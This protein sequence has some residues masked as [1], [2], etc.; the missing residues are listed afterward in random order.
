M[1][2]LT[3][4]SMTYC[5]QHVL[6]M[7]TQPDHQG[8]ANMDQHLKGY[9]LPADSLF[10]IRALMMRRCPVK[11][12]AGLS[13]EGQLAMKEA[14]EEAKVT[15]TVTEEISKNN[16]ETK[17]VKAESKKKEK[18]TGKRQNKVDETTMPR[19]KSFT[20]TFERCNSAR[21]VGDITDE[22]QDNSQAR[23]RAIGGKI[24]TAMET[25]EIVEHGV[26]EDEPEDNKEA[27]SV[28]KCRVW[29]E[30]NGDMD[31]SDS[32]PVVK[33]ADAD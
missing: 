26:I 8:T 18:T 10:E 31:N 3:N 22:N 25:I 19:N 29:M 2:V 23:K 27:T 5:F 21:L 17:Q 11:L 15:A 7:T 4:I 28:E 24:E 30:V 32:G 20:E 9:N 1:L 14:L 12:S 16:T 33:H 13:T 6:T